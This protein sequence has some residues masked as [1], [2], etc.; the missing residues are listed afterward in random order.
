MNMDMEKRLAFGA[1][2]G[3]AGTAPLI[4]LFPYGE[5]SRLTAVCGGSILLAE[6]L[7]LG[8]GCLWGAVVCAM[9]AVWRRERGSFFTSSLWNYLA[10]CAAFL[11]W[12]WCCLGFPPYW[13]TP[14]ALWGVF[15]ALYAIGWVVRWLT[16]RD[17]IL[18]I[19]RKLGLDSSAPSPLKWRESLPYLVLTAALFLLSP[20]L[21]GAFSPTDAPIFTALILPLLAWPFIAAIVG[22]GAALRYGLCPLLP[23]ATAL[24]FLPALLW[25][26]YPYSWRHAAAYA[27]LSLLGELAG[28]LRREWKRKGEN[29]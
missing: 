8:A 29:T 6:F 14:A 11:L 2:C 25:G 16:C 12:S 10:D 21:G 27:A 15:T 28:I 24:A 22:F 7:R 23:P 19:R 9:A 4:I 20:P 18:A 17:D 13:P 5:L 3:A 1:L 26:Y